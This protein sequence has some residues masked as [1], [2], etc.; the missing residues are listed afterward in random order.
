[1]DV[2]SQAK[3]AR[4][5]ALEMLTLGTK[6]KNDAL[7]AMADALEAGT[8]AI[9]TANAQDVELARQAGRPEA[10]IDRLALN[11]AR[12]SGM[13]G[14]LRKVASLPDPVGSEDHTAKRPNGLMISCRRVPLGVVGII[15]EAR[16]NVTA[17]AIGLCVKSGNACVLRGG[18]EALNSNVAICDILANTAYKA[19]IPDGAV[20]LVRDVTREGAEQMMHLN[21]VIDV[22]IPRGGASLIKSV[23]QNATLPVIETGLGNCHVFVDESADAEMAANIVFNAKTSRPAVCNAMETL[24]VY[25]KAAERTL[26]LICERLKQK[27]VELRCCPRSLPLVSGALPAVEEDWA[28]EYDD[29]IL[30]IKIVDSLDEAIAHI[31]RYGTG[32]S[33][34]IVTNDYA[35]AEAFLNRVDSAAV[36]VNAS[37]RFTDGEEFGLGA[38]IGISTQKL[39]ARGPMGL[40]EL[41]TVKYVIRGSGQIR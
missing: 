27:N 36:Y 13:A 2:L 33:D 41:T 17:D 14:G 35:N 21:G 6:L 15:F 40:K 22:L 37:T 10:L 32:H 39:H 7:L 26:P 31:N 23:V 11:P 34:C 5:A 8:E 12:I 4:S 25:G 38:E 24:L 30:A 20:Q 1:M 16:P 9:L 3:E 19:G 29:Y 18:R 28:T